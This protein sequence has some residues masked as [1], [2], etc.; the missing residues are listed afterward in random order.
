MEMFL[1]MMLECTLTMTAVALLFMAVTPLLSKRY[2]ARSLCVA[3]IVILVGFVVPLRPQPAPA[4]ITMPVAPARV[5]HIVQR[6]P[7]APAQNA[8]VVADDILDH[9]P[10]SE[11]QQADAA[12]QAQAQPQSFTWPELTTTHLLFGAWLA[13]AVISLIVRLHKHRRFLR[14]VRRWSRPVTSETYLQELAQA[15]TSLGIRREVGLFRCVSIDS[16]MLVG[17]LHPRIL[18]PDTRLSLAE[19]HLVFRHELIHLRHGDLYSRLL[20]LV[21]SAMHW[22]NPIMIP[23]GKALGLHCETACD[24]EVTRGMDLDTREY[25]GQTILHSIRAQAGA[26]TAL[27]TRYH[28]GKKS[29]KKRILNIL[30]LRRKR[31]GTLVVCLM[32]LATLG[33]GMVFALNTGV[34]LAEEPK[35]G[36]GRVRA[37]NEQL[38]WLQYDTMELTTVDPEHRAYIFAFDDVSEEDYE[39]YM[40]EMNAVETEPE[41]WEL[42]RRY[43]VKVVT[44]S[45]EIQDFAS[46][47]FADA[48]FDNL[49]EITYQFRHTSDDDISMGHVWI[50]NAIQNGES[51]ANAGL[52]SSDRLSFI[53]PTQAIVEEKSDALTQGQRDTLRERAVAFAK[54][55]LNLRDESYEHVMVSDYAFS[56]SIDEPYSYAWIFDATL[57]TDGT[58]AVQPYKGPIMDDYAYNSGRII[59]I[60]LESGKIFTIYQIDQNGFAN[61][62]FAETDWKAITDIPYPIPDRMH[63]Y[64]VVQP[65]IREQIAEN[66]LRFGADMAKEDQVTAGHLLSSSSYLSLGSEWQQFQDDL[67]TVETA[68][69][70]TAMLRKDYAGITQ[71]LSGKQSREDFAALIAPVLEDLG[72]GDMPYM[73]ILYED[74]GVWDTESANYEVLLMDGDFDVLEPVWLDGDPGGYGLPGREIIRIPFSTEGKIRYLYHDY[75]KPRTTQEAQPTQETLTPED[76]RIIREII[77]NIA[78]NHIDMGP[79]D[80]DKIEVSETVQLNQSGERIVKAALLLGEPTVQGPK[81]RPSLIQE[82]LSFTVDTVS[83]KVYQIS[84]GYTTLQDGEP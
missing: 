19:M 45:Q 39:R 35:D 62:Y 31:L 70:F 80:F 23:I 64:N 65:A 51:I 53:F 27:S 79:L 49:D 12:T 82:T 33:T 21:A 16:P 6:P 46:A 1:R 38:A 9:A 44:P 50:L 66:L 71:P 32:L 83:G 8:G 7:V 67:D 74:I 2:S 22:F 30:D 84:E 56:S 4:A 77:K 29:M 40:Q 15:K 76:D 48:G 36:P 59:A 58:N 78:G 34:G 5:V 20:L 68:A 55:F 25:Y 37:L 43:D 63:M 57:S 69:D 42:I 52:D 61:Q 17:F 60:G 81:Y 47:L 41:V 3:W 13:G 24:A 72:Y 18:L 73:S 14:T 11:A 75:E 28:G 10:L 26:T 54:S